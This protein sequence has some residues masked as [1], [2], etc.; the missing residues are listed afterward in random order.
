MAISP[1]CSTLRER[2]SGLLA[3][4]CLAEVD[5]PLGYG[6]A[7]LGCRD[8]VDSLANFTLCGSNPNPVRLKMS[9]ESF[10]LALGQSVDSVNAVVW[11]PIL[12]Y[13]FLGVGLYFSIRTR[14][15]QVRHFG[16]MLRL[17][18]SRKSSAS[19]VSSFQALSMSLSGRVGT[20]NIAGVATAITFGGPGA[21]FW[22]WMVAFLGAGTA[23]VESTLA[24][25]Y[26]EEHGGQFRGGPAFFIEKGIGRKWY[27]W[28]FAI[29]T[30]VATG[31]LLPG[32][33][34]N[35]IAVSVETAF[36]APR[37]GSALALAV[38]LTFIIFGGVKRIARFAELAVPFM[39]VGYVAIALVV[40]G[41]NI[42][43]L[44][45][46]ILLIVQ[47]AFGAHAAFGAIVGLAVQWGVKR[48]VFSNEAGQGTG[49]QPAAA[50][51]V[52]HPAQQ[53]LV[54][55]FSVYID[56]LVV[57]SA[58]AFMLLMTD[59]YNVQGS[60]GATLMEGLPGVEAG[61][62]YTQT[63]VESALPGFGSAFVA[64]ALFCFAFTTLVAYYYIAETNVAYLNRRLNSPWLV[65]LLRLGMVAAVVYSAL[66][67]A[68]V[69]WGLGDIGVG[70]MAW[71]NIAAI[72]ILQRPALLALRDY[73][74][75]MK[76]G[77][78]IVFEPQSLGIQGAD[79]WASRSVSDP[80]AKTT[81]GI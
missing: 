11:S 6:S 44:P 5:G 25:I 69:A 57:C 36:G 71:L 58:T 55:S 46:V 35:S 4:C 12:V 27:A 67:T 49:C 33:Q 76:T 59:S 23:Y 21:I 19:G 68:S 29:A 3:V 63:A 74:A 10:N 53:G 37:W 64:L 66:R 42:A 2:A 62:I 61:P 80:P 51:E 15:L 22:M 81:V 1:G 50:A 39:A 70:I 16:E 52:S 8:N 47:S 45:T 56:T 9:L 17:T 34:S 20:G 14:F 38:L 32:V 31:I 26:K 24:Q 54:Q 72:L 13:L 65:T 78:I 41:C 79:Y 75:Q 60:A 73:E 7:G 28:V 77:R 43:K 30:I 40:I 18:F 48:G